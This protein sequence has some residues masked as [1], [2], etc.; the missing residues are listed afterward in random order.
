MKQNLT[1][2]TIVSLCKRRGFIFQASEI[3]GGLGGFYDYGPLGVEIVNKIKAEW[4]KS[5]VEDND[6]IFGIDG[7]II[8]NP[9][10]WEA[11]GHVAG[12]TDPMVEDIVT[13][14]RYRADHLA[15]TDSTNLDELKL[16]RSSE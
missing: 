12:F 15:G 14:K 8:Q 6:N 3:Y 4:W 11:S 7:S 13:H 1:L 2:E 16:L 5:V 10:L 9:K